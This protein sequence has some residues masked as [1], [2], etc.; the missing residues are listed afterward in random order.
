MLL[1]MS[2]FLE[3]L[4]G[5]KQGYGGTGP[6]TFTWN[7]CYNA[8]GGG[9]RSERKLLNCLFATCIMLNT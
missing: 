5:K 6:P 2:S 9:N 1:P 7:G 3:Q 8:F 4:E